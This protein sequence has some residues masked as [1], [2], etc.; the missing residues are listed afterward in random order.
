MKNYFSLTLVWR[1]SSHPVSNLR[2]YQSVHQTIPVEQFEKLIAKSNA[3]ILDVA[4]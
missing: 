4:G 1:S 2:K 3:Q